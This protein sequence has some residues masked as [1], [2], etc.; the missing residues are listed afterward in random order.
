VAERDPAGR[1][2]RSGVPHLELGEEHA[3]T[4]P[5][6]PAPGRTGRAI[7]PSWATSASMP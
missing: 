6:D 4:V 1:R 5:G 3:A 7:A 2:E